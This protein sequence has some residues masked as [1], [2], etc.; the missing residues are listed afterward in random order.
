M[1]AQWNQKLFEEF[2]RL[3]DALRAAKKDKNYQNV[4]LLGLKI[5]DLDKTAGFLKIAIP[6]FLK[7]MAEAS[8]KLGD[9]TAAINYLTVAKEKFIEQRLNPNDWQKDI[10]IICPG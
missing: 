7:D 4:I 1:K 3:R 2:I 8:I 5:I 9:T 10:E 6:I